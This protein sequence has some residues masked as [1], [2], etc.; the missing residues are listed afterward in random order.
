M[1]RSFA[2]RTWDEHQQSAISTQPTARRDLRHS[3]RFTFGL[4]EYC[5][6]GAVRCVVYSIYE[7]FERFQPPA[8]ICIT[9]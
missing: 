1:T 8:D 4:K 7:M 5:A 3:A 2:I 9:S 6:V